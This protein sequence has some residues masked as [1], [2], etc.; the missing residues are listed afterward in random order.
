MT[1]ASER[2][3]R[4][5]RAGEY[6]TIPA[7]APAQ[8]NRRPQWGAVSRGTAISERQL[9]EADPPVFPKTNDDG[10]FCPGG[11]KPARGD[12]AKRIFLHHRAS[13]KINAVVRPARPIP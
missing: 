3:A 13:I 8:R 7:G 9:T 2:G 12:D 11:A 5:Y 6:F 10:R 1:I 4:T